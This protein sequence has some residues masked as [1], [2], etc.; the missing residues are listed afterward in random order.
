MSM[1]A[2]WS[3]P[4]PVTSKHCTTPLGNGTVAH[5][6]CKWYIQGRT[7]AASQGTG[8]CVTGGPDSFVTSLCCITAS[9]VA[10]TYGLL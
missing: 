3:I 4:V 5:V 7:Q 9:S 10:L 6:Q 2:E 8:S 1:Q